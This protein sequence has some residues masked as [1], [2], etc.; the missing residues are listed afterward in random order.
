VKVGSTQ[1]ADHI[2]V[3]PD[4]AQ[5][6]S[7]IHFD[8]A[9]KAMDPGF[10]RDDDQKQVGWGEQRHANP[11]TLRN[12]GFRPDEAWAQPNLRFPHIHCSS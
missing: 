5:R 2:F 12:V 11:N 8:L 10:R 6:R 7:G 4:A 1:V 3:I 9:S